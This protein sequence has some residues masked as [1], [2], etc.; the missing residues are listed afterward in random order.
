MQ[1][2]SLAFSLCFQSL[3]RIDEYAA[4]EFINPICCQF[5]FAHGISNVIISN[6]HA[7]I[8]KS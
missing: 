1:N 2:E 5:Y 4:H 6:C 3:L 8:Y 7:Q